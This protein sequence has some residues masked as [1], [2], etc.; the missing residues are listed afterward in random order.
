[1]PPEETLQPPCAK[2]ARRKLAAATAAADGDDEDGV[3]DTAPHL[4]P[5]GHIC[6]ECGVFFASRSKRDR[7]YD[8]VHAGIKAFRCEHCAVT[9]AM[10]QV[11]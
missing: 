9:F 2:Q 4:I 1:M 3:Y 11:W 7:H 5:P 8:A 10:P 6:V